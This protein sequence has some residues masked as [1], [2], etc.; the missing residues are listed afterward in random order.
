MGPPDPPDGQ[1]TNPPA[2][3]RRRVLINTAATG[4]GNVWAMV[5]AL[6]SLPLLLRGLGV[7]AFGTWTLLQTLSVVS[8]WLSLAD[9]GIG[10]ATTKAV[11]ERAA[12]DDRP[13]LSRVVGSALSLYLGLGSLSALVLVSI[14]PSVLPRIFSTPMPLRDD[15]RVAIALFAV[16]VLFDLLTQAGVAC[17][18]GLQRTD[19]SRAIDAARRT[20]VAGATATVALAGGGLRGVALASLLASVAGTVIAALVLLRHLPA[21]SFVPSGRE[22]R[23]L[24]SYGKVVAPL[25]AEGVLR[26]TMDRLIVGSVIGPAAVAL[27]E[28]ATQVLNGATSA[29]GATSYAALPSGS[30]LGA[31]GD[32]HTLRELLERGTKYSLLA[33]MPFITG[34]I[35]LS[36]PLVHVWVGSRYDEAAGLIAVALAY[37][38]LVAPLQVGSNLLV[39]LGR[40]RAM[41]GPVALSVIVNLGA[42]LV[43]VH[44][45][46][47][48]GVFQGT[49][50]GAMVLAYPLGRATL[51]TTKTSRQRFFGE[52]ILPAVAPTL[53]MAAVAGATVAL[54]LGDAATLAIGAITGVAAYALV[55]A[56]WAVRRSEIDELRALMARA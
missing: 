15:L 50:I 45:V 34:G 22:V 46:G 31:R 17:L 53:A 12:L 8:G 4:A 47:I 1:S 43:L 52:A 39:A 32:A 37:L 3:F 48:V 24:A 11:A 49:V 54:P 41:I 10:T 55:A 51:A 35:V 33:T 14:G 26:R 40:A 29:L 9:L 13:G 27:V 42:S 21:R 6:V 25:R 36:T 2:R 19:I 56:R 23:S 18:E 20:L 16:Q 5:V 30:W 44:V 28:I 7:T 38:A